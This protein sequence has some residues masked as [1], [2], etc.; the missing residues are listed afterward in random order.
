MAEKNS[1]SHNNG[2]WKRMV[3][4]QTGRVESMHAEMAKIEDKGIERMHAAVEESA[5]LMKDS[6]SWYGEMS[7][8]FRK[9]TLDA[10]RRTA[11]LFLRASV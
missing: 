3:E 2:A 8:E 1:Q 11:E 7:A 5:R 6:F 10:T 4:E 9:M